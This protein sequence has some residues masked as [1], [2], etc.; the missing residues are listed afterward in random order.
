MDSFSAPAAVPLQKWLIQIFSSN[1]AQV[2]GKKEKKFFI[3]KEANKK[4][5]NQIWRKYFKIDSFSALAEI[6]L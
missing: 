6:S 1:S 2:G 5:L 4:S 3:A